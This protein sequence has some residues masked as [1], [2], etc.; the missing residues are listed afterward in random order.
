MPKSDEKLKLEDTIVNLLNE[1]RYEENIVIANEILSVVKQNIGAVAMVC[2]DCQG[3][4]SL[5]TG[6]GMNLEQCRFCFGTGV[7]S[8]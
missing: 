4:G 8:K 1:Y 3:T 2:P 7:V 6:D 5:I